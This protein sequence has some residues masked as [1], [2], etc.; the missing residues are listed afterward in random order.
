VFASLEQVISGSA[1]GPRQEKRFSSESTRKLAGGSMASMAT[2]ACES[3]AAVPASRVLAAPVHHV[4]VLLRACT[5]TKPLANLGDGLASVGLA[6]AAVG[7][8]S[9]GRYML[10]TTSS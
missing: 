2:H 4:Q 5:V 9:S 1:I 6:L 3:S 7:D 8:G 10:A